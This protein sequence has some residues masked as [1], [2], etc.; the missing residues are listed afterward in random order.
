MCMSVGLSMY[1]SRHACLLLRGVKRGCVR[2]PR[3]EVTDDF[4]P[5]YGSWDSHQC[6]Q[7]YEMLLTTDPSFQP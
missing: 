2:A 4:E 1:I 6:L 7:Q 5:P 3:P